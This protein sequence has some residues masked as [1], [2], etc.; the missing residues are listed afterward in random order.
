M[1]KADFALAA[2]SFERAWARAALRDERRH[3]VR[4]EHLVGA[5]E[6]CVQEPG[7]QALRAEASTL[8]VRTDGASA[9]PCSSGADPLT[10]GDQA[11]STLCGLTAEMGFGERSG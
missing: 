9:T 7:R 1:S 5:G 2:A 4:G 3:S 10:S 11:R 8:I 6:A